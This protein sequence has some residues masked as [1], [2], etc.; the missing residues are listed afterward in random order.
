MGAHVHT[1]ATVVEKKKVGRFPQETKRLQ[2]GQAEADRMRTGPNTDVTRMVVSL[3]RFPQ[4][5]IGALLVSAR[6]ETTK[7]YHWF[8][9][10][11]CFG[12]RILTRSISLRRES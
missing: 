1:S 11:A 7:Q 9:A 10:E 12:L 6:S 4:V 8:T 2:I 5:L 3:V